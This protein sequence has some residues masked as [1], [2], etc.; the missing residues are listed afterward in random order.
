MLLR[1]KIKNFLSFYEE[2]EFNM[3]PN[4]KRTSFSN[5]VY[6]NDEVPLLKQAVIYGGNGS[7][8]S[9]L[10]KTFL[11]IKNFTTDKNFLTKQVIQKS[12]F[13]L[14]EGNNDPIS[15]SIEFKNAGHYFIYELLMFEDGLKEDLYISGLGTKENVEIFRRNK[16]EITTKKSISNE[17]KNA[18]TKL[19]Q[20]N[21]LS[22]VIALNNEFPIIKDQKLGSVYEWFDDKLEVL[23]LNRI[24][25]SLIDLMSRRKEL[26]NFTNTIFK[27]ID[28]GIETLDVSTES[29]SELTQLTNDDTIRLKELLKN[30]KK[31]QEVSG[32]SRMW[33]DKVLFNVIVEKGEQMIKQF[34]FKQTG[35]NNYQGEMDIEDQSD[36]TVKLLNLIP[37]IYDV[38]HKEKV[39]CIDELENSIHPKLI[40]AIVEFYSSST[41][42]G[43][44]I[45]STHEIEL[46]NQ[47]RLMRPDEVWFTEKI[48]G[49]TKL[50]SLN[51]FKEHSTINI[52]NG[53][54]DGRYGGVPSID[55]NDKEFEHI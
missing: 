34:V 48:N 32:I 14:V 15:I 21:P 33:N 13:R 29:L 11:F 7:G 9:N 51:D 6:S 45:F 35:I 24:V 8:K 16:T 18:T 42:K 19:L 53:Y 47:Q 52:K 23:S 55:I 38:V 44:L 26:L 20:S 28:L 30:K 12:K 1:I 37:A 2:T 10:L 17:I 54:M 27:N 46:L 5:H 50:Y 43:Q 40:S 39:I 49:S 4:P 3:F 36:G 41:T 22:S 31:A 25:P